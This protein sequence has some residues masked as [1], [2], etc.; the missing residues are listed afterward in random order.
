MEGI[1]AAVWN[2]LIYCKTYGAGKVK[3]EL[4]AFGDSTG[5]GG[6]WENGGKLRSDYGDLIL[7]NLTG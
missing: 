1:V 2:L 4:R 5:R 3:R 7:E 6:R